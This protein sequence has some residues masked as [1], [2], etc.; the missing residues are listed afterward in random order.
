MREHKTEHIQNV[1]LDRAAEKIAQFIFDFRLNK[2]QEHFELF[3]LRFLGIKRYG[4]QSEI[5]C[6]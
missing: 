2:F 5:Q 6:S 4:A 1:Q 3:F